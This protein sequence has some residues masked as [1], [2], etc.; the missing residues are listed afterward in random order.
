MAALLRPRQVPDRIVNVE[1]QRVGQ[2]A[3][4]V[5]AAFGACAFDP[6]D[7]CLPTHCNGSADQYQDEERRR[8]HR[9]RVTPY[10]S[11]GPVTDG[12]LTREYG[13]TQQVAPEVLRK[14]LDGG[15]A[16]RGVPTER[17]L[18]NEIQVA[19][20]S[21]LISHA[22]R[23]RTRQSHLRIAQMLAQDL[24]WIA[25]ADGQLAGQQSMQYDSQRINVGRRRE[26][27]ATEL[28]GA[29]IVGSHDCHAIRHR[30]RGGRGTE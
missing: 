9:K 3:H 11:S 10:E 5:E 6:D 22:S 8:C 7:V 15:I 14:L 21:S 18:E 13:K 29:G 30:L 2:F 24:R 28:L 27:L 23:E 25:F 19:T 12:I 20:N 17:T 1:Y 16:A 26:R 4:I